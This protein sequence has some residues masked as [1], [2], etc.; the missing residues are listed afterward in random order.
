MFA[1]IFSLIAS[2]IFGLSTSVGGFT[3]S[4]QSPSATQVPGRFAPIPAAQSP[5]GSINLFRNRPWPFK[6]DRLLRVNLVLA[7]VSATG[8]SPVSVLRGLQDGKSIKDIAGSSGKTAADVLAVYD[9]TVEF[10]F[11]QAQKNGRLP[12]GLAQSRIDWY[13]QA[14]Q[15]MVDQPGLTP[16]YPGLHELH[17]AL[18]TAAVRVGGLE[19]ANV[20]N[21]LKACKS[22][23]GIL[24]EN[25]HTGQEVVEA[26][27]QRL[28]IALGRLVSSGKLSVAQQQSWADSIRTAL[29]MMIQTPGLHVAG[30][31]CA[32]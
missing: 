26:A 24:K 30:K 14:A 29:E 22:L 1:K 20:R 15:Q 12:A 31:E 25:G 3:G 32:K 7:A 21:E 16:P 23:D 10:I 6:G 27:M 11:E 18:I 13:E 17:V 9:E 4:S 5:A 8:Q 2:I 19:R 28:D